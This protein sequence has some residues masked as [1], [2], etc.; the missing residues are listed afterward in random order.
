[1]T[2]IVQKR[3]IPEIQEYYVPPGGEILW[4]GV[5]ANVPTG[6]AID[7]YCSDVFIRGCALGSS[8]NTPAGLASHTH[9]L[10]AT[11]SV[12]SHTH[13]VG[14]GNTQNGEGSIVTYD[15][16]NAWSADPDHTHTIATGTS[17]SAGGHSHNV[18][19]SASA[20]SFPSYARLY[21]LKTAAGAA[22]PL[23]GIMMF[24]N[25]IVNVPSAFSLCNGS[26]GTIDLREKFIYGAAE[27]ADVGNF[28]GAESHVHTNPNT[29]AAGT[30]THTFNISTGGNTGSSKDISGF[31][32]GD[33]VA[34][35]G[36]THTLADTTASDADHTHT[37]SNTGSTSNLPPYLKLYF[38]QRTL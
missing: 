30:H 32:G 25:P 38:I 13:P 35:G 4:Y 11:G 31:S 12:A 3:R 14:G 29:D 9:D 10:P 26:G 20:V 15:S 24:D 17:S 33:V 22:F 5:A 36:H 23:N 16:A 8:T 19:T 2:I 1:M 21:W 7:S 28:G 27:D 6:F 18:T 34:E 37:L